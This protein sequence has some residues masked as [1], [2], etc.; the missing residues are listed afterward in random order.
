MQVLIIFQHV[1][2]ALLNCVYNYF[3]SHFRGSAFRQSIIDGGISG[4]KKWDVVIK[5]VYIRV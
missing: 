5:L 2:M 3:L 4:K 1:V